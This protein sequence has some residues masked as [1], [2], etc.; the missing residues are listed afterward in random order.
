MHAFHFI[1]F[2]VLENMFAIAVITKKLTF[3]DSKI[4][5][6]QIGLQGLLVLNLGIKDD[7]I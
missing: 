4:Q 7:G 3:S 5:Y 1:Q 2:L 6:K